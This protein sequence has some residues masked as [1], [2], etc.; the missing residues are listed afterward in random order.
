MRRAPIVLAI[1][2][3]TTT[4]VAGAP[5]ASAQYQKELVAVS[6]EVLDPPQ[7]V[8]YLGDARWRLV[9]RDLSRD[10]VP[11][12]S[13][14]GDP[15]FAHMTTFEVQFV[16]VPAN[17]S[18]NGWEA[19]LTNTTVFTSGGMVRETTLIVQALGPVSLNHVTLKVVATM[20]AS[21]GGTKSAEVHVNAFLE[22]FRLAN[23][24]IKTPPR[25]VEQQKVVTYL[26]QVDNVGTYIDTFLLNV[27][28]TPGWKAMITPRVVIEGKSS[29]FVNL[30]IQSPSGQ[31]WHPGETAIIRVSARSIHEPEVAFTGASVIMVDGPYVSALWRPLAALSLVALALLTVRAWRDR[32]LAALE[33]G[34]PRKPRPTPRQAVLLLSLIHI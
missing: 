30:T 17:A 34:R 7:F 33:K 31:L 5:P 6:L 25:F 12:A 22:P 26:V 1:V 16:N 23:V 10:A 13:L 8:P 24:F 2:L 18:L 14:Q 9:M 29:A 4:L 19:A 3:A 15:G 28:I 32:D 27:S 11:E 21:D 20:R